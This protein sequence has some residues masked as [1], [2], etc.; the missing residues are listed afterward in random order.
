M[1]PGKVGSAPVAATRSRGLLGSA[2]GHRRLHVRRSPI[3]PRQVYPA[4]YRV[5]PPGVA[6]RRVTVE[7]SRVDRSI[8]YTHGTHCEV[9][10]QNSLVGCRRRS[11]V[12]VAAVILSR[13]QSAWSAR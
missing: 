12:L 10:L 6:L 8:S 2:A 5:R 13:F 7:A 9:Q 3:R 1:G 4:A 11:V